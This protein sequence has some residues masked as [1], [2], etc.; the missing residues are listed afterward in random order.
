LVGGSFNT[1]G[2][3]VTG[4]PG[5]FKKGGDILFKNNPFDKIFLEMKMSSIN[6]DGYIRNGKLH[7]TSAYMSIGFVK[8]KHFLKLNYLSGSQRTG[9]TWEGA[10]A[11]D[12]AKDRRYNPAGY[13]YTDT[14]GNRIYYDNETDNYTSN[15]LQAFYVFNL[16][17]YWT[18]NTGFNYTNG[19]G[20]YEN[21]RT[22]QRFSRIGLPNLNING[23]VYDRSDIIRQKLMR[24]NFY[25]TNANFLYS[26]NNLNVNIGGH[27]SH[28][29]GDY[30]GN[31]KWIKVY[32]ELKQNIPPNHEWYKH[33]GKKS[34][35]SVFSKFDYTFLQKF[36]AFLDMQ[37]RH[38]RH[39]IHGIDDDNNL[40]R[41]DFEKTYPFFNPKIGLS[42]LP[43]AHQ[44][45]YV[46]IA[47]ASRE[48]ARA[49][50]KEV[51]RAGETAENMIKP[52][53][54]VDYELG[55]QIQKEHWGFGANFYFMDYNDQLV[56]NGRIST[57]G[58]KLMDNIE[59]SYRTG[60]ELVGGYQICKPLKIDANLTLSQSKARNM[61]RP[62]I[63]QGDWSVG[64]E[65]L[66]SS[67]LAFSPN[68]VGAGI[69]TYSPI[70]NFNIML[71]GKY[72]GKQFFDNL[73]TPENALK[74]YFI[75][76]FSVYYERPLK[77]ENRKIYV[78]GVIN[79]LFNKDYISNAW[80]DAT[81]FSDGTDATYRGFFAQAPIHFSIKLGF[82]L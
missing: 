24:N 68:V 60:I 81:Y 69:L 54:L 18:F 52:E 42:Y 45:W 20:Y 67:D 63:D 78:Q 1:F 43:D 66:K 77:K 6:S 50:I 33:Q 27:Y 13:M 74:A 31:L 49:D 16:S 41:I 37:F 55:Y 23:T 8:P 65:M 44:K 39:G 29:V 5:Y 7:H 75:S 40:T 9:I 70:S 76:D 21:Y 61:V 79:N 48:P 64:Y 57:S 51:F 59:K 80:V 72:V 10:S 28:Y 22:G 56:P 58:Y 47:K 71:T 35:V 11:E 15:I 30:Y 46:S 34:E 53:H 25:A 17:E 36:N 19:F 73:S 32:E 4:N 38:V 12:I 3:N 14:N 2:V 62:I 82:K 26:K